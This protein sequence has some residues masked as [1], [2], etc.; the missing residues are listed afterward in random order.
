MTLPLLGVKPVPSLPSPASCARVGNVV[1]LDTW[2]EA[3]SFYA[4]NGRVV[5]ELTVEQAKQL[6][7]AL[8]QAAR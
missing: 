7:T 1:R 2:G 6:A 4:G 8:A 5:A 3:F